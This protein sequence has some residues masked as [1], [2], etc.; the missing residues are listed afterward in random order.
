LGP[1]SPAVAGGSRLPHPSAT[2]RFSSIRPDRHGTHGAPGPSGAG[3]P[4]AGQNLALA[5]RGGR[6][7]GPPRGAVHGG[8]HHGGGH[9]RL[10]P[11]RASQ[12]TDAVPGM[13]A[14]RI[15]LWAAAPTGEEGENWQ[16]PCAPC[17]G[18]RRLGVPLS[19]EGQPPSTT[20]PRTPTQSD[21]GHPLEGASPAVQTL[22]PPGGEGE[23]CQCCD[24]GHRA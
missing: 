4:R 5:S 18:R 24:R 2:D 17:V 11:L 6:P 15:F 1:G 16:H 10:D 23:T 8:R 19:R 9:W 22:P 21:A 13:S 3:T 14:L 12:R 20:A 7:P